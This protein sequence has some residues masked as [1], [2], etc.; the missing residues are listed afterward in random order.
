MNHLVP[1]I[2]VAL[3]ATTVFAKSETVQSPDGRTAIHIE[4]DASRFSITRNGEIVIASSP[5]GLELDGVPDMAGLASCRRG[6]IARRS[7]KTVPRPTM[8]VAS[9]ASSLHATFSHC[10]CRR[11]GVPRRYSNLTEDS[12]W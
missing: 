7:G 4:S 1:S 10:I 5:L 9:S 11:R 2:M 8:S 3:L 12:S 6:N